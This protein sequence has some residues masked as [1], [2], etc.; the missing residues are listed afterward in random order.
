MDHIAD[1]ETSTQPIT[2]PP[3]RIL[4]PLDGSVVSDAA[5]RIG[6]AIA[7]RAGLPVML[8]HALDGT[9]RVDAERHLHHVQQRFADVAHCDTLVV[10]GRAADVILAQAEALDALV[11]MA[12]HGR[13][14]LARIALGSV[15]EEVVR[16]STHG[17]VVVGPRCGSFAIARERA[18]MLF[19]TD[20][21]ERSAAACPHATR[22]AELLDA[23]TTVVQQVPPDEDVALDERIPPRPVLDAA[24]TNCAELQRHFETQGIT[25]EAQVV[26]GETT[27]AIVDLATSSAATLIALASHGRTGFDRI[28]L[29]STAASLVRNAPCPLF[30]VGPAAGEVRPAPA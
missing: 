16:R 28:T 9:D 26:F 25:V 10:P 19:C 22:I 18:S 20:G 3:T 29:G 17:I 4:I 2:A 21:S 23:T 6:F 30:V 15:A 11:C 13:G 27:R 24:R 7:D 12:S 14:G 1:T 8:V 5:V